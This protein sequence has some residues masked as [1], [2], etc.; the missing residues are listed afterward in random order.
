[1][2]PEIREP[3]RGVFES[4]VRGIE[5][6]GSVEVDVRVLQ[7]GT[8]REELDDWLTRNRAEA[9]VALGRKGLAAIQHLPAEYRR[10][11]GAVVVRPEPDLEGFW[12]ISLTP[13]PD[14]L[15]KRLKVMTPGVKRVLVVYNPEENQWLIDRA[16]R[17]A[18]DLGLELDAVAAAN[19]REAATVY[20]RLLPELS[21][22]EDAIWLPQDRQTVDERAILPLILEEAWNG[23]IVLFSSSP[24]HVKRGAL[25]SLYPDYEAMGRSLGNL[26]AASAITEPR[27]EPLSDLNIAVNTRTAEHLGIEFSNRDRRGFGL[28]YPA[29]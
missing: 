26:A 9:V 20:R 23:N 2:Y 15:F 19:L 1:L 17:S 16:R 6:E 29:R 4:I 24:K 28:M 22:P 21:G 7:S 13:A 25:F 3:Y 10:V 12:G 5:E 18:L 27:I 11:V 8:D 14:Q